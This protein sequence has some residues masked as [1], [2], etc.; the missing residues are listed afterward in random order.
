MQDKMKKLLEQIGM[1]N[2]YLENV[3]GITDLGINNKIKILNENY[4]GAIFNNKGFTSTSTI[5]G[6]NMFIRDYSKAPVV[7]KID[8]DKG[9][10]GYFADNYPESELILPRNT[11]MRFE[12]AVVEKIYGVERIVLYYKV[13]K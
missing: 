6:H 12:K 7:M 13:V 5:E 9:F 11:R 2:D 10:S 1:K 8:I 4:S 3:F